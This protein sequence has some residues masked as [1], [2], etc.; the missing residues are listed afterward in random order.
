MII[1]P[2]GFKRE[3]LSA[4]L[5]L[6]IKEKITKIATKYDVSRSFVIA[7]L[8]AEALNI[9]GQPNYETYQPVISNDAKRRRGKN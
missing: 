1:Q 7:T 6:E 2:R 8:L 4:T 3:P 5:M 9:K